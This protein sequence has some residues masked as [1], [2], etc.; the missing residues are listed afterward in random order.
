[1]CIIFVDILR[2]FFFFPVQFFK[3]VFATGQGD[4]KVSIILIMVSFWN[5]DNFFFTLIA[6][7]M[8]GGE[9][10]V[11]NCY[12]NSL[13]FITSGVLNSRRHSACT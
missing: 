8:K 4:S 11:K 1:M 6:F 12:E 7:I 10:F 2:V 9:G 3:L 13:P 5:W